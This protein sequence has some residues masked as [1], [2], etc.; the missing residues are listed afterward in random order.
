M[1]DLKGSNKKRL[2]YF[3]VFIWFSVII[4][5][6]YYVLN[7]NNQQNNLIEET[8]NS[9]QSNNETGK[10]VNQAF[11][12]NSPYGYLSSSKYIKQILPKLFESWDETNFFSYFSDDKL[13]ID[14]I[15]RL[16][17]KFKLFK[18]LGKYIKGSVISYKRIDVKQCGYILVNAEFENSKDVKMDFIVTEINNEMKIFLF[19][20]R[21]EFLSNEIKENR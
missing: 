15:N 13:S 9:L 8:V 20:M 2:I 5:T 4:L 21:S 11:N 7:R 19:R 18:T 16:K 6:I 10:I 14:N 1:K 17:K 3:T 12:D